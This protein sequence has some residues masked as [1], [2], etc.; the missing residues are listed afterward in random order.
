MATHRFRDAAMA[1]ACR[2]WPVFPAHPGS[3]RPAITEWERRASTDIEWIDRWWTCWPTANPAVATGPAGLVVLDLDDAVRHG[4][5]VHRDPGTVRHGKDAFAQLSQD[6]AGQVSEGTFTVRTPNNGLHL[7]FAAPVG[8]RL[9]NTQSG[10]GP[11]IDTRAHG[12]YVLAAGAGT[13][14][15]HYAIIHDVPVQALPDWL[16]DALAPRPHLDTPTTVEATHSDAYLRAALA[17]E[18]R[19]VHTALPGTRRHSLLRAACRMGRLPGLDDAAITRALRAASDR[20]V[21]DGAYS[22]TERDRAIT[23]GITW[24]RE[25]PRL[26]A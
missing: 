9:H 16:V 18:T 17:D 11:L 8:V 5:I 20:H 3:K 2:G 14:Q 13:R 24:G 1:A 23:D 26:L 4:N 19:R 25:H 12:G 15:G 10:L 22:L 7:Y 21:A 6:A